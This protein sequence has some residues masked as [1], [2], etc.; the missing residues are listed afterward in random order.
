MLN[1]RYLWELQVPI[2]QVGF[3]SCS[4]ANQDMPHEL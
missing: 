4:G 2:N 3:D 1:N